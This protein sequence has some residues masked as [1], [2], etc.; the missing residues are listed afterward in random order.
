MW[1]MVDLEIIIVQ[2]VEKFA[3]VMGTTIFVQIAE[4]GWRTIMSDLIDRWAAIDLADAMW[5]ATH[6]KNIHELWSKLKDL[7]SAEKTGKWINHKDEHRCSCCDE[8]VTGD[9]FYEDDAYSYCPN[10]GARMV[11]E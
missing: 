6:D 7:P 1:I 2:L 3:S 11:K 5:E 10:C 9:W 4:Q 8:V